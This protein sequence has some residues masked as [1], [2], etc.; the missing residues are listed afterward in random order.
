MTVDAFLDY[1]DWLDSDAGIWIDPPKCSG[2]RLCTLIWPFYD[3][4]GDLNRENLIKVPFDD[5]FAE[6]L[7]QKL[8]MWAGSDSI[9]LP[10][11]TPGERVLLM[12]RLNQFLAIAITNSAFGQAMPC[13]PSHWTEMQQ[14]VGIML[15]YIH[16]MKLPE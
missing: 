4:I 2:Y 13:A 6:R 5:L 11:L 15:L 12:E 8:V 14:A 9:C 7:D 3:Q 1:L 10:P 16:G